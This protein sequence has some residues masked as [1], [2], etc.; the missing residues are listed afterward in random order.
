MPSRI[1]KISIIVPV[2][3]AES[4][5]EKCINSIVTQADW[6][7]ELIVMDGGSRDG[8]F[9]KVVSLARS[10]DKVKFF[11]E[12]DAGQSDAMNKGLSL[13]TG[14]VIGFVNADDWLWEG[15]LEQVFLAFADGHLDIFIGGITFYHDPWT[16]PRSPRGM[17]WT[18]I[19]IIG[20]IES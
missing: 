2:F 4:H 15:A 6:L 11:S 20:S 12:D 16:A 1:P 19:I 5:I 7:H 13:A 8:T 17:E 14:S 3:N 9:E 18:R 10:N